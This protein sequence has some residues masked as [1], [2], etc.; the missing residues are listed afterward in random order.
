MI[1]TNLRKVQKYWRILSI[2][3]KDTLLGRGKK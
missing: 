1:V 3:E 2:P